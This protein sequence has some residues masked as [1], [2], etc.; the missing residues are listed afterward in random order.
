[1]ERENAA[2]RE[3]MTKP[4][5]KD[6]L[7]FAELER[8]LSSGTSFK[9]EVLSD[10]NFWNQFESTSRSSDTQQT[11]WA[12]IHSAWK[13][14]L[15][16]DSV[17]EKLAALYATKDDEYM[18]RVGQLWR[19]TAFAIR[20]RESSLASFQQFLLEQAQPARY[21]RRGY[22]PARESKRREKVRA[23]LYEN[24]KE[25]KQILDELEP[26]CTVELPWA[27]RT[28]R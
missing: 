1:M 14:L 25:V 7:A 8:A 2:Q 6:E 28:Y 24:T 3:K 21:W 9:D 17:K 11:A 26:Y 20:N 27:N 13:S 10:D 19:K 16:D 18:H 23:V 5:S 15:L 4:K 12:Q 22:C